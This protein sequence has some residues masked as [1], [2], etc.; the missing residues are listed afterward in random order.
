MYIT[1]DRKV[2]HLED[3]KR[4]EDELR[5]ARNAIRMMEAKLAAL[6]ADKKRRGYCPDCHLL[7][8]IHGRC[9]KCGSIWKFHKTHH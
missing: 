8:T 4:S 5:K 3:E 9:G 6:E 2:I 7:L 1:I